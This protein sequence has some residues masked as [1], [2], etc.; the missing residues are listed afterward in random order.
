MR[1][2]R[3]KDIP[4]SS[5]KF[6]SAH[7]IRGHLWPNAIF[8]S[9]SDFI[10]LA[11]AHEKRAG[12]RSLRIVSHKRPAS[13]SSKRGLKSFGLRFSE[14]KLPPLIASKGYLEIAGCSIWNPT[15]VAELADF[16]AGSPTEDAK[17]DSAQ[18]EKRK[19][20]IT[21]ATT[22]PFPAVSFFFLFLSSTSTS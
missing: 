1:F 6:P 12:W 16:V 5:F 7:L 11:C 2:E 17:K 22:S 21:L 14:G 13:I 8:G 19:E 20:K 15:L 4:E 3:R 10:D 18:S 9:R